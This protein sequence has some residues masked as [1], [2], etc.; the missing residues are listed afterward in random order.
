M[1]TEGM[2]VRWLREL[3]STTGNMD[4]RRKAPQGESY[5]I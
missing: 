1:H 2:Q 4:S 3:S 5:F